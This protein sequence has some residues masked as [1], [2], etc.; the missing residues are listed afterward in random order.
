[1]T[2]KIIGRHSI[3]THS[4][5]YWKSKG[6]DRIGYWDLDICARMTQEEAIK[7]Q[8]DRH[9]LEYGRNYGKP[10]GDEASLVGWR[11]KLY[12]YSGKY[13]IKENEIHF[14]GERDIEE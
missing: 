5:A 9:A 7:I 10:I 2:K 1:M 11:E 4:L 3:A 13:T 12:P 6:G 8:I 14:F